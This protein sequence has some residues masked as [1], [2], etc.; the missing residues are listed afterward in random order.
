MGEVHKKFKADQAGMAVIH[1]LVTLA[2]SAAIA[3]LL[4]A[5]MS[6]NSSRCWMKVSGYCLILMGSCRNLSFMDVE[7]RAS[8]TGPNLTA[9]TFLQ[10]TWILMGLWFALVGHGCCSRRGERGSVYVPRV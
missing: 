6:E 7:F 2:L 9:Y 5:I 3:S 1:L 4:M 8:K 10:A